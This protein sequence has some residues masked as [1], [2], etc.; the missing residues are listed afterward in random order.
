[1]Y[2]FKCVQMEIASCTHRAFSFLCLIDGVSA[3]DMVFLH[4]IFYGF[5][6]FAVPPKW[7]KDMAPKFLGVII[8]TF[9]KALNQKLSWQFHWFCQP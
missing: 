5:Y 8:G 1:M 3:F 7:R 2:R 6:N 4:S 9:E